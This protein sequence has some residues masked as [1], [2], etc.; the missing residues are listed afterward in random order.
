M[1]LTAK[2]YTKLNEYERQLQ[3]AYYG[4]YIF[5]MT[6][7]ENEALTAIYNEV[8][9]KHEQPSNCNK[10]RLKLIRM[11]GELYFKAKREKQEA[12]AKAREAKKGR[13]GD[14]DE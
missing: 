10:C 14:K 5:G 13:G 11:L 2:E 4:N 1:K 9:N 8:F 12:M 6:H 3:R 7:G